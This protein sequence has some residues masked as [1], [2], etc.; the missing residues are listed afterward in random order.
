MVGIQ[1][2]IVTTTGAEGVK[3]RLFPRLGAL[4]LAMRGGAPPSPGF[5]CDVSFSTTQDPEVPHRPSPPVPACSAVRTDF[6]RASG[7]C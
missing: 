1:D 7:L 5:S 4:A 2:T 3:A 6:P